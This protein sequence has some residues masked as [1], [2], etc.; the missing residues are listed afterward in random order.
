[1]P[2][3][4]ETYFHLG[5]SDQMTTT[6]SPGGNSAHGNSVSQPS[7]GTLP[8]N[9]HALQKRQGVDPLGALWQIPLFYGA[10]GLGTKLGGGLGKKLYKLIGPIGWALN[11]ALVPPAVVKKFLIK[12]CPP[13]GTITGL[14]VSGVIPV[15]GT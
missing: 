9:K 3:P 1:M 11:K 5:E 4:V 10:C 8:L 2:R 7:K 6:R 13:V 15:P 12:V 14:L